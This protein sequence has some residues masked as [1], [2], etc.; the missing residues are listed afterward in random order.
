MCG[1]SQEFRDCLSRT[2]HDA[3]R[4]AIGPSL[5]VE[6]ECARLLGDGMRE[7]RLSDLPRTQ[8]GH[9]GLTVQ[10]VLNRFERTAQS[11]PCILN[12]T[13]YICKHAL[14]DAGCAVYCP[15]EILVLQGISRRKGA[16]HAACA[17][18]SR[19]TSPRLLEGRL[20]MLLELLATPSWVLGASDLGRGQCVMGMSPCG[21]RFRGSTPPFPNKHLISGSPLLI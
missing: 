13:N 3:R 14:R 4:S 2:G 10:C 11:H 16:K 7:R 20:I 12:V 6:V 9:S 1:T 15:G 21:H 19:R 8:E 17:S 18:A 5:E